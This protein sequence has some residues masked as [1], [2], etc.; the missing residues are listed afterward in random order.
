MKYPSY[1]TLPKMWRLLSY[2]ILLII[3]DM[4]LKLRGGN[5]SAIRYYL[6]Y[7]LIWYKHSAYVEEGIQVLSLCGG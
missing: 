3:K 7:Q 4:V 1:S 5:K 6:I 2:K